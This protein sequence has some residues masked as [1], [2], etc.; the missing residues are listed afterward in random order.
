M[1][2]L[3][4]L[5]MALRRVLD[6]GLAQ[7]SA[8]LGVAF[9]RSL[10][11]FRMGISE[12]GS[13]SDFPGS[14]SREELGVTY[15]IAADRRWLSVRVGYGMN[16]TL[17]SVRADSFVSGLRTFSFQ[18]DESG[19]VTGFEIDAGPEPEVPAQ[20]THPFYPFEVV[21]RAHYGAHQSPEGACPPRYWPLDK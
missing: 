16:I 10:V 9:D 19:N 13:R 8:P 7:I 2:A 18:R 1:R 12:P 6:R 5:R 11:G 14:Y 15:E 17:A 4:G 21:S 3:T 20:L